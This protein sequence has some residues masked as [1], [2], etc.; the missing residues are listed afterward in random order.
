MI[1]IA[2]FPESIAKQNCILLLYC[3]LYQTLPHIY[4]CLEGHQN[5]H[6]KWGLRW[7]GSILWAQGFDSEVMNESSCH[8]EKAMVPI[9]FSGRGHQRWG[10]CGGRNLRVYGI[11]IHGWKLCFCFKVR[12]LSF[13]LREEFWGRWAAPHPQSPVIPAHFFRS[14][15]VCLFKAAWLKASWWQGEGSTMTRSLH[16]L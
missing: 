7:K 15:W 13:A 9:F 1:S 4:S 8:L 16:T 10:T 2:T 5:L 3:D 12:F 11:F 6:Q 14:G